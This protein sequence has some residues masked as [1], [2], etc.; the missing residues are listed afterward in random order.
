MVAVRP[1]VP[2]AETLARADAALLAALEQIDAARAAYARGGRADLAGLVGSAA[3]LLQQARHVRTYE[4][5]ARL[6]HDPAD[7]FLE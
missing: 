6:A 2:R 7:W 5:N 1:L 4:P 3:S